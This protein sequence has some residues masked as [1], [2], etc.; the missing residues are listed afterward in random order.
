MATSQP[1]AAAR[2][3]AQIAYLSERKRSEQPGEKYQVLVTFYDHIKREWREEWV[4]Y[5]P[6]RFEVYG[7]TTAY[8]R[9]NYQIM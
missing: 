6:R 2:E 8:F 9:R 7:G 1:L 5:H 4:H 3:K